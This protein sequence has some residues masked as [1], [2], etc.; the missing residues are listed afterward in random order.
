MWRRNVSFDIKEIKI[1]LLDSSYNI[2]EE[3]LNEWRNVLSWRYGFGGLY[4]I[5]AFCHL[6]H[7]RVKSFK[8][9]LETHPE[10]AH[11]SPFPLLGLQCKQLSSVFWAIALTTHRLQCHLFPPYDTLSTQQ[12]DLFKNTDMTKWPPSL[13]PQKFPIKCGAV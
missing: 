12:S 6:F 4:L 8:L 11:I 2:Q 3:M 7:S 5:L 10:S 13:L 1:L 9:C